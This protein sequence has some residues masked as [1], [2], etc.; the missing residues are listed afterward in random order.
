V[1][2]ALEWFAAGNEGGAAE[3]VAAET[4]NRGFSTA[5]DDN[6]H[7]PDEMTVPYKRL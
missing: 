6:S 5:H 4:N 2:A 3:E 7:A 1:G